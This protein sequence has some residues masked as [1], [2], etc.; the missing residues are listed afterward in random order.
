MKRADR[1]RV[2]KVLFVLFKGNAG[3]TLD[4]DDIMGAVK[5]DGM[6][7]KNWLD[8]RG[9]LQFFM[10]QGLVVRVPGDDAYVVNFK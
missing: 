4:W 9:V 7:I 6:K 2:L 1:E 10:D 3:R 8:V 5:A